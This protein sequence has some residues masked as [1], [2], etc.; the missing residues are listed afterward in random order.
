[1]HGAMRLRYILALLAGCSL[2]SS[3][4]S[5]AGSANP[6]GRVLFPNSAE[7]PVGW[8]SQPR[9]APDAP[10]VLLIMTDDEGF[11]A[12]STF[13]GLIPTPNFDRLARQGL[14]YNNFNTTGM[15]SPSRASL[16]TGRYPHNAAMGALSDIAAGYDGYS[17]V[18]PASTATVAEILK[19]GGYG[20]AMFGKAHITP[21]WELTAAGPFDRWPTGLGFQYFY[22]FLQ[23]DTNQFA[24]NLV[25]NTRYI[26]PPTDPAYFF[27]KDLADRTIHWLREQDQAD[28]QRPFFIYYAPG[29]THAPHHASADWIARFKGQFDAGWDV[30]RQRIF[31]R[32]KA[33]G[34][35]PRDTR[36]T[37]RPAELPAWD[38]LSADQKR[39]AAR[40]MEAYAAQLAYVDAQI[41]RV[42]DELDAS[43]KADKTMVILIQG[44]NG[45][46]GEGGVQG[47]FFEQS[48]NFN[49]PESDAFKRAHIDQIGGPLSDN[50]YPAGWAWAMNTPFRWFKQNASHFGGVRNGLIIRW[51]GHLKDSAIVRGQFSHIAD[52]VP[53]ILDATGIQT[54]TMVNGVAQ[55]PMDGISLNYSFTDAKAASRRR[56]QYFEILENVSIYKDGWIAATRPAYMPWQLFSPDRPRIA[57]NER[58]W[59][60]YHV[61]KDFSEFH[62][63]STEEPGRLHALQQLFL[64]E[65][66]R[67][68]VFPLHEPGEGVAGRP[69][70]YIRTDYIFG[71]EASNVHVTAAPP[72]GNRSYEITIDAVVRADRGNGVLV[73]Q[74]GRFNGFSLYL[75]D[76]VPSFTYNAVPP[77]VFTLR[78]DRPLEP[79]QHRLSV[80]FTLDGGRDRSGDLRFSI[81]GM[82][83]G[84]GHIPITLPRFWFTE[85]LD[86][87]KDLLT[88]VSP[89]Y[90]VPN[91]FP[92]D[93]RSVH[94]HLR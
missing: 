72:L 13:G 44:D 80:S 25:E 92:G 57:F 50:M 43:G 53:T 68:N 21:P 42:L 71:P 67:N 4:P 49:L 55:K 41:G 45:A 2:L 39:I 10:N 30:L 94:F 78:A 63:L 14:R 46:S 3:S 32:Q 35:I 28:P 31:D 77:R 36:L 1:M 19:E 69:G 89:D 58:Q 66:S 18:I 93:I 22:G 51:P 34:T 54:P 7:F 15:C 48:L 17:S 20:T 90:A 85:G 9:P 47:S 65:G 81:D 16:L 11:G 62:D 87:G 60:L 74:G 73:A 76:G 56:T 26:S 61:D 5:H 24:P 82:E 40:F 23:G 37:P 64:E 91:I 29:A 84:G 79:G 83:A 75:K 86:V 33:S 52:I 12:S 6:H 88:P 8:P 38:S 70:G 27:E 59:E